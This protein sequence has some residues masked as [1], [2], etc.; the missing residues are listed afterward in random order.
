MRKFVYKTV[1][2]VA[3]SGGYSD[4]YSLLGLRIITH[5]LFLCYTRE[6]SL[7]SSKKHTVLFLLH[8]R[9]DPYSDLVKVSIRIKISELSWF[10]GFKETSS[11]SG[12]ANRLVN[13][14][15]HTRW[16]TISRNAFQAAVV[17]CTKGTENFHEP[18]DVY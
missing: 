3:D 5:I 9:W 17:R 15:N 8:F 1:A 10:N 12:F 11:P 13:K 18:I 16:R 2:I 7:Y 4:C 6:A 14:S